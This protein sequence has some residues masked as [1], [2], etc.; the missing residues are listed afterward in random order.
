MRPIDGLPPITGSGLEMT[1]TS[2]TPAVCITGPRWAQL[3]GALAGAAFM[4]GYEVVQGPADQASTLSSLCHGSMLVRMRSM[5]DA[6]LDR[7]GR[8]PRHLRPEPLLLIVHDRALQDSPVMSDVAE[9]VRRG[10]A[11]WVFAAA[12]CPEGPPA[13]LE[14]ACQHIG[15]P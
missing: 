3:T 11:A 1:F 8:Y 7:I 15:G 4:S 5:T 6:G 10:S 2:T 9:I 13:W 14:G 12:V